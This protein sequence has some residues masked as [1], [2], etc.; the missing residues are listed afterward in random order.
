MLL[1]QFQELSCLILGSPQAKM[2]NLRNATA[3]CHSLLKFFAAG[4]VVQVDWGEFG[5]VFGDGIKIHYFAM[6]L[7]YSRYPLP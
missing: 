1:K 3:K 6:V 4:E 2:G 5:D 7:A